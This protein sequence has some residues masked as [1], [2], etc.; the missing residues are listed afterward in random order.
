MTRSRI[1]NSFQSGY[2]RVQKKKRSSGP[3]GPRSPKG[4]LHLPKPAL[5]RCNPI[6]HQCRRLFAPG[7]KR[8]FAPS[9]NHFREFFFWDPLSQAT[10]FANL[11]FDLKFEI[12]D[13]KNLVKFGGRIFLPAR[14]AQKN[15]ERILVQISE[16]ISGKFRKLRF[17][18]R[19]FFRKPRSAEGRC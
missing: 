11:E 6:L 7:S 17:K 15:S 5:H 4:L 2:E 14:K 18:F 8:P 3:R 10:W 1:G 16:Q 13:E 19:D 12:S 9:R